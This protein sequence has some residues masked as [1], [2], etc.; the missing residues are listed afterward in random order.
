MTNHMTAQSLQSEASRRKKGANNAAVQIIAILC[1]IIII[2]PVLYCLSISFMKVSD[3][4]SR[5]PKVLPSELYVGNYI[6]AWTKSRIPRYLF[7]SLFVSLVCSVMRIIT[8]SLAGYGFAFMEFRGKKVLFALVLGVMLIPGDVILTSNIF[9][10]ILSDEASMIS[11]SIGMLASASLNETN[12]GLY[13][14][15]H[16]SAPDIAGQGIA[17]PLATILSVAMML[18]YSLSQ[19]E[20]AA[21]IDRAVEKALQT[22]RTPDIWVEGMQRVSCSEMG[23]LVCSLIEK[24]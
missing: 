7:N 22:A 6:T 14:P 12:S 1:G 15:I 21:A 4:L 2:I 18:K 8:A 5:P 9:G 19:P 3:I 16:G 11:G 20:A 17:N 10:D 23:D 13:E 24:A